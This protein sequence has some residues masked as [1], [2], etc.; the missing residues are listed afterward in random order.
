MPSAE[1]HLTITG[2]WLTYPS[3]EYDT[4]S[5]GMMEIPKIYGKS[6]NPFHGSSHH[7]ADK[8]F[9]GAFHVIPPA[10]DPC[11]PW[12]VGDLPQCYPTMAGNP[13]YKK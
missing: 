8:A 3:E 13:G 2:W 12:H 10:L 9:L 5:V 1:T 7:Q 6:I 11:L 4:S